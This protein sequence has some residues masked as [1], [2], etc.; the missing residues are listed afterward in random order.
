[1]DIGFKDEAWDRRKSLMQVTSENGY[2]LLTHRMAAMPPEDPAA[3]IPAIEIDTAAQ[4][5]RP[6][7][8]PG[9]VERGYSPHHRVDAVKRLSDGQS[10]AVNT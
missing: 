10:A 1:M 4:A 9:A 6:P 2:R 7:T 5:P 3:A 8:G